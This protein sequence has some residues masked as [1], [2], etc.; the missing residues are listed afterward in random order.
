MAIDLVWQ[1]E[2]AALYKAINAFESTRALQI[3]DILIEKG[4][5]NEHQLSLMLAHVANSRCAF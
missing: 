1:V 3:F 2:A 5:A 4:M